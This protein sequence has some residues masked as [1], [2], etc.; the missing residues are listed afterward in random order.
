MQNTS[1]TNGAERVG[2]GG[3]GGGATAPDG[4]DGIGAR[5][6]GRR[7]ARQLSVSEL[8]RRVGVT[9][10]LI[11]QIER[12]QSRPSVATLFGL[13]QALGVSVDSFFRDD[14]VTAAEGRE[15]VWRPAGES[16]PAAEATAPG[17]HRPDRHFVP[18]EARDVLEIEGGVSWERLTP[19]PLMLEGRL[20]IY[21]GF[22]CY[23]LQPGDSI[24][25]PSSLPHRYVNPSD[26]TARAV[27]A[28]LREDHGS[29][30]PSTDKEKT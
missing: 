13:A 15:G 25:F 9:P 4:A 12:G 1:V 18:R 21:V 17:R 22:E 20:D 5:V 30:P 14:R 11:S 10:S 7:R 26:R 3:A 29:S 6:A 16:D 28:I 19:G 23:Q 27:T 2:E 24:Y 8:A